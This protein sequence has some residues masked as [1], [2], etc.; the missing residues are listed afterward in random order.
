M[1]FDIQILRFLTIIDGFLVIFA[2]IMDYRVTL[3]E[4]VDCHV[5]LPVSKSIYNRVLII[6]ALMGCASNVERQ[7]K[8][9]QCDDCEVMAQA[10]ASNGGCIDVEDA[11]TA[12]RFLT[13]FFAC[14]EGRSVVL[15]GSARMR[16]R[17]IGVLVDALRQMGACI[18][19]LGEEGFPPLR[20]EGRRLHGGDLHVDGGVS[21][22]YISALLMI[23]PVVGG[24]TLILEGDVVSRPYIDMTLGLMRHF[25]IE[26]RY[27]SPSKIEGAG[28]RMTSHNCDLKIT[29]PEGQYVR[30][31]LE[32]EGDWSAA[33]YW[34]AMQALLPE[35][36]ITLSPLSENSLQGDIAI[37]ELMKPLGVNVDYSDI[38]TVVLSS[39][40]I[41]FPQHY[42]RDMASAPDLVPTLVVT[43]CLLRVPFS[44][45]GL[46]SLRIKESD[47]VEALRV[48]LAKLGYIVEC[49]QSSMSYDGNHIKPEDE[50]VID[51]HGDHRI[52]MAMS[53][54]ATRHKGITIK[55]AEVVQKSYPQWWQHLNKARIAPFKPGCQRGGNV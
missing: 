24:M 42:E 13:A 8:F 4:R 19:Y 44:I 35:S 18:V 15:D 47:R 54:A 34:F 29:V 50:V 7:P 53:L 38:N 33:S 25:G 48:E 20:I 28:G 12:M 36:N 40:S 46:Q 39:K 17:P 9:R 23:A 14:R 10:L 30:A 21:S 32:I 5:Q 6:D 45:T 41:K 22:Q 49:D 26:A 2:Q 27:N 52:A 16:E 37:V 43:L 1:N 3:P 31:P 11:G 51:P 55:N